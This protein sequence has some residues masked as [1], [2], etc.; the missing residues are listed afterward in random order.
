MKKKFMF[1]LLLMI[2]VLPFSVF[3]AD[4]ELVI[5]F[6]DI[7][8][9]RSNMTM[10]Q[11]AALGYLEDMGYIEG[12]YESGTCSSNDCPSIWTGYKD[13]NGTVLMYYDFNTE[14]QFVYSNTVEFDVDNTS[15][16]DEYYEPFLKDYQKII[17]NF[18][19]YKAS[20]NAEELNVD[21]R[22]ISSYKEM[23]YLYE[24]VFGI[25]EDNGKLV[26]E[27]DDE[28]LLYTCSFKNEEGT[29][30]FHFDDNMNTVVN[31]ELDG[32]YNLSYHFT[33]DEKSTLSAF[34][35]DFS[36]D[37]LF[38]RFADDKV[39]LTNPKTSFS[40]SKIIILMVLEVTIFGLLV[41]S[42]YRK[43]DFDLND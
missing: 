25:L 16:P 19:D 2:M 34:F 43:K 31:E 5:N 32:D 15:F 7:Y 21:F 11:D 42:I 3:A 27:C 9:D 30:L 33:D 40:T 6:S 28:D 10:L 39:P 22:N 12:I 36:Y 4:G 23:P 18:A 29:E 8:R 37:S 17:L 13:S 41:I 1:L 35:H 24:M 14:E 26:L 38:F 20:E